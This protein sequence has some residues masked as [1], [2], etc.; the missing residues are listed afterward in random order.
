MKAKMF[1]QILEHQ[2]L[3]V[4]FFS[5][6]GRF[7]VLPCNVNIDSATW[8]GSVRGNDLMFFPRK[9]R[10]RPL[11]MP[12]NRTTLRAIIIFPASLPGW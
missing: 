7:Y 5:A 9:D 3:N 8:V 10:K 2:F 11:K 12:D 1:P 4:D 6:F